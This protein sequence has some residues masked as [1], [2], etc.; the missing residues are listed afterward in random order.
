[1]KPKFKI[2]ELRLDNDGKTIFQIIDYGVHISIIEGE[3]P[4]YKIKELTDV[5]KKDFVVDE[6]VIWN[7]TTLLEDPTLLILFGIETAKE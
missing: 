1:M 2:G 4:R 5:N 6:W 7:A 3:R